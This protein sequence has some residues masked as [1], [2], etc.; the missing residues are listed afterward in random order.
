MKRKRTRFAMRDTSNSLPLIID[1]LYPLE[2]FVVLKGK[3]KT[4][5]RLTAP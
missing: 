4:V 1:D 5:L 2:Y 3:I